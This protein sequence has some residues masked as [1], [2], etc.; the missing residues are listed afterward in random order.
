MEIVTT[1]RRADV[2]FAS[3][4]SVYRRPFMLVISALPGLLFFLTEALKRTGHHRPI[5]VL[6]VLGAF[7]VMVSIA[8][9]T[10]GVVVGSCAVAFRPG[11]MPGLLGIHVYRFTPEGLIE[12]TDVNSTTLSW[13]GVQRIRLSRFGMLVQLSSMSAHFIPLRFFHDTEQ[14]RAVAAEA[15]GWLKSSRSGV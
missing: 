1:I 14:M 3:V 8:V 11:R 9:Y 10:F 12:Q 2:F 15:E 7:S 13:R 4:L 6:T 5:V